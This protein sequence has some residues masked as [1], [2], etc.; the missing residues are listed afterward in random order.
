MRVRLVWSLGGEYATL[1]R[2]AFLVWLQGSS[3]CTMIRESESVWGY[4]TIL[5]MHT[6]GMSMLVGFVVVIDLRLLGV[7]GRRRWRR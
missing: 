1:Q 7:A 2:V 3:V 6:L 4:P 5:F